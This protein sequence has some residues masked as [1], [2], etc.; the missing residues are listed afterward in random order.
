[1]CCVQDRSDGYIYRV[2][3]SFEEGQQRNSPDIEDIGNEIIK[4]LQRDSLLTPT[5][6]NMWRRISL[7]DFHSRI[8]DSVNLQ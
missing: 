1:M 4:I 3:G 8:S 5:V 2:A 7:F 6:R